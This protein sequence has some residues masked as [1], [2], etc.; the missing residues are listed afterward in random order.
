MPPFAFL[1]HLKKSNGSFVIIS[2]IAGLFGVPTAS[3][4]CV[5]KMALTSLHQSLS[6]ELST[7]N[8]HL[9]I[10]YLGFTENDADN[11]TLAADGTLIPVPPRIK[12]IQLSQQ[13]TANAILK[14]IYKREKKRCYL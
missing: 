2:P 12:F 8:V 13:R 10:I 4:Y 7:Y 1:P 6:A 11:K 9:G 3:A 5:G 14:M